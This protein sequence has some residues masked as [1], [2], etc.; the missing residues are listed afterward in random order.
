MSYNYISPLLKETEKQINQVSEIF[1]EFGKRKTHTEF[2]RFIVYGIIILFTFYFFKKYWWI[3]V[4]GVYLYEFVYI[5]I[6]YNPIKDVITSF[7][8]GSFII[9]FVFLFLFIMVFK[10]FGKKDKICSKSM[11]YNNFYTYSFNIF[12]IPLYYSQDLLM[13]ENQS[14]HDSIFENQLLNDVAAYS[15]SPLY[16][17]SEKLVS[18]LGSEY[19]KINSFYRSTFSD[20]FKE[21]G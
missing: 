8:Y 21:F 15:H 1:V 16:R 5:L 19:T 3:S 7:A 14:F 18:L 17:S 13:K 6:S 4:L 9:P 2:I 12:F 10:S 11:Q 20:F